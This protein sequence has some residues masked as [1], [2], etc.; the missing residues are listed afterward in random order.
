[1]G[2]QYVREPL[3]ME[4][5]DKLANACASSTEKLI[6]WPLIDCGLRISE[7]CSLTPANVQWQQ[8]CLRIK[9]KGG[10]MGKKSKAR[11]VPISNRVRAIFEPYFALHDRFPVGTRQAQKLVKVVANRA[12]LATVVTPHVLR[13]TFATLF[14]QKGGSLAALKKIL[15]HDRLS[16]TEIYLNLTDHHIV[17]EYHHKW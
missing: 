15:G 2:Y 4:E 1:M 7:L 9:G 16:T 13:H 14:L 11:V 10:P 17:E 8:R 5:A 6:I 12:Q 3:R